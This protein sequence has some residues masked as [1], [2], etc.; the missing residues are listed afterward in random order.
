[1]ELMRLADFPLPRAAALWILLL[2][3]LLSG[4][5]GSIQA[6]SPNEAPGT[7][8]RVNAADMPA[9][10]AT[11]AV[12]NWSEV[13]SASEHPSFQL[14]PGFAVNLFANGFDHARWLA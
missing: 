11:D 2:P 14:P 6:A 5:A 13:V 3:L 7:Q 1:M 10:Y 8:I 9:P 4:E 12:S